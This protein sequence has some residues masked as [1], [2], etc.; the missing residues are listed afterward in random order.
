MAQPTWAEVEEAAWL[1]DD[2]QQPAL[3]P[4]SFRDHGA[5][6]SSSSNRMRLGLG[7][8]LGGV[9]TIPAWQQNDQDVTDFG[10][11]PFGLE[12]D[13]VVLDCPDCG[14]PVLEQFMSFHRQNCA[15]VREI[16]AGTVPAS[17]LEGK[18]RKRALSID[19]SA[20]PAN[21]SLQGGGGSVM[22]DSD[23]GPWKKKTRKEEK[24]AE[25]AARKI[26]RLAAKEAKAIKK[27][28]RINRGDPLNVDKQ[29]GVMTEKG[30][31]QRSLTCKSHSMGAK[32]AVPGRSRPYDDLL[33]DW[34]KATNPTFVAK[35]R[36]KE[37]AMAE[38]AKE[39][40]E[41]R[42]RK[43]EAKKK[44]LMLLGSSAGKKKKKSSSSGKDGHKKKGGSKGGGGAGNGGNGSREG[45]LDGFHDRSGGGGG[46]G[47]GGPDGG[48]LEVDADMYAQGASEWEVEAEFEAVLD[49]IRLAAQAPRTM[50]MPLA[51]SRRNFGAGAF[52]HKA[53]RFRALRAGPAIF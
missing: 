49:A 44:R 20:S 34:Q 26:A 28:N 32:R 18:Q 42:A 2:S 43:Q 17:V 53:M 11:V 27:Q 24:L 7:L 19:S 38:A 10:P 51:V 47:D 50:A 33:F 52:A 21:A 29:C 1:S 22:G 39:R 15:L 14:K 35:L 45:G 9:P 23:S 6:S 25:V 36:E 13:V 40:E 16:V 37:R 8:G 31:C 41:E 5:G 46:G 12:R 3:Q 4:G 30:V 48:G